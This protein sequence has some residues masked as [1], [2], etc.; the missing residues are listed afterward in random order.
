MNKLKIV[1]I[2]LILISVTGIISTGFSSNSDKTSE[3][4]VVVTAANFEATIAEGVVL[5]DFWAPWCGPCRRQG[6]IIAEVANEFK[7]KAVIGKLD[8][9]KHKSIASK[10]YISTIPTL[11]IFKD[12]KVAERLVGLHTKEKL[13]STINIYL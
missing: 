1:F 5:V 8:V 10:Y 13:I 12:G 11:I 2:S 4:A 3:A 9:D 6:P 7:G